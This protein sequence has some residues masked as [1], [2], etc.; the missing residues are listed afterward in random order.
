[1]MSDA[2][3]ASDIGKSLFSARIKQRNQSSDII[4]N[5]RYEQH[6]HFSPMKMFINL[7]QINNINGELKFDNGSKA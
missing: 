1:M 7:Q 2:N 6:P 5:L 3:E 4:S